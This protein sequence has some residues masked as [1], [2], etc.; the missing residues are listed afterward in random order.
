MSKVQRLSTEF[1]KNVNVFLFLIITV[2]GIGTWYLMRGNTT[3]NVEGYDFNFAVEDTAAIGKIFLADHDG[4]TVTLERM[5]KSEWRVNKKYKARP[6]AINNLL[7]TVNKITMLYRFPRNAV[8]PVIQNLAS[9]GIKAEI[10]DKSGIKIKCYYVGGNN[11]DETATYFIMEN[12][13]EPYPCHIPSFNGTVRVRYFTDELDWRDRYVFA[14]Q[15]EDIESVVL[16][17]PLQKSHSFKLFRK[18]NDFA[19]APLYA[20]MPVIN[21]T[22]VKA[23]T[24]NFL[25]NF[26]KLGCEGFE[27]GYAQT[28]SVKATVPFVIITVTTRAGVQT[29]L[30]LHPL[31]AKNNDDNIIFDNKKLPIIERYFAESSTGDFMMVQQVVFGKIF[32]GYESFFENNTLSKVF[33]INR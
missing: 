5:N 4:K 10:Y 13:N 9:R 23:L 32:W 27:N 1:M 24:E 16:D 15:P 3:S 17:Y 33:K 29:V 25:L 11:N 30:K 20:L 28:D 26:N 31:I 14:L 2:L 22:P 19:V 18:D 8:K 7:A 21:K 12:A 6:D